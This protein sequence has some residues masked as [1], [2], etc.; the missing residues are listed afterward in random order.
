MRVPAGV[1]RVRRRFC[2]AG[3]AQRGRT[4]GGARRIHAAVG[5]G[6]RHGKSHH[7]ART[8]RRPMWLRSCC[9]G[10]A[11]WA[12]ATPR[13][14]ARTAASPMAISPAERMQMSARSMRPS[15]CGYRNSCARRASWSAGPSCW[16]LHTA[17]Q[18][19]STRSASPTPT[20]ATP[21]WGSPGAMLPSGARGT[22]TF[23]PVRHCPHVNGAIRGARG[24]WRLHAR[25]SPP[26]AWAGWGRCS[27]GWTR[28]AGRRTSSC[29]PAW[30]RAKR[31]GAPACS[32]G[33]RRQL[34]RRRPPPRRR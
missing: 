31:P 14:D 17:R 13:F 34:P 9:C 30:S 32:P 29:S 22:T 2:G 25:M 26:R 21:N 10:R 1:V 24:T 3:E 11:R 12:T 6:L 15:S 7:P 5:P 4:G 28:P 8:A 33:R 18:A 27:S 23:F 19:G 16:S 20:A